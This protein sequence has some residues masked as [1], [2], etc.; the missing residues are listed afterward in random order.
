MTQTLYSSPHMYCIYCL[1]NNIASQRDDWLG[2]LHCVW[3]PVLGSE[4][5]NSGRLN[6][7]C[8]RQSSPWVVMNRHFDFPWKLDMYRK[9]S[10][11]PLLMHSAYY[12]DYTL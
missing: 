7:L 12:L 4:V 9:K 2:F 5:R 8:A 11:G 3:R 10:S 6:V 1:G